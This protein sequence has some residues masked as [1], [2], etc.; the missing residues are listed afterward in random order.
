MKKSIKLHSL[1]FATL[2]FYASNPSF[3]Q[4]IKLFDFTDT[5]TGSAPFGS[6]ISDGTYLYGMTFSGGL[7]DRGTIFKIKTD[8]TDFNKLL[9]FSGIQNGG[10]PYGGLYAN[11]DFLYGVTGGGGVN[12]KGVLF[13]IK[14]DGSGFSILFQFDSLSGSSPQGNL[15]FDGTYLFGMTYSN[16][17]DN[18]GTIYKIKMDGSGFSKL[19]DF[20]YALS[21]GLPRG[22]LYYDGDFLFGMTEEGGVNYVG[23]IFK[24][25]TDGTGF[26]KIFDFNNGVFGRFPEGSFISDGI[27]LYGTTRGGGTNYRGNIFRIKPDGNDYS[28]IVDFDTVGGTNIHSTLV[29]DG[30]FFYGITTIGGIY[31]DGIIYRVKPDGSNYSKLYEFSNT[32][33]LSGR[34]PESSL[35]LD[36]SS[37]YGTTTNGGVNTDAGVIYK[38]DIITGIS[39]SLVENNFSVYPNPTTA[40]VYITGNNYNN[41]EIYNSIGQKISIRKF[42][43]QRSNEFDLSDLPKGIY[44]LKIYHEKNIFNKKIIVD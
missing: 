6:L 37:L 20:V 7:Y 15:I 5:I 36:G 31:G 27:Y 21:G 34:Y 26:S 44:L 28:Q 30:E 39:N 3:A 16:G 23:T 25:K 14:P 17:T 13:K 33:N 29:S 42:L 18:S 10:S 11:G 24:I 43:N 41:I 19:Y 4:Y 12:N 38:L 1:I 9:D 8:G 40:K 32:L 35:L 22:S 2:L